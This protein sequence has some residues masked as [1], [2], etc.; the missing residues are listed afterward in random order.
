M[1]LKEF[2]LNFDIRNMRVLIL[3]I[4]DVL[5]FLDIVEDEIGNILGRVIREIVELKGL[6]IDGIY[7]FDYVYK[8][9]W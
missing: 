6:N 2:N 4:I 1:K 7:K 8:Y 9:N 5:V 3:S